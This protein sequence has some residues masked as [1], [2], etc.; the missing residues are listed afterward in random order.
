MWLN[1][2][3]RQR[4]APVNPYFMPLHPNA[5][6]AGG[7]ATSTAQAAESNAE[8]DED[9]HEMRAMAKAWAHPEDVHL[10]PVCLPCNPTSTTR[11]APA[12]CL[13]IRHGKSFGLFVAPH[14]P[15]P[16]TASC[17]PWQEMD[18]AGTRLGRASSWLSNSTTTPY[19]SPGG[20]IPPVVS[21]VTGNAASVGAGSIP[22]FPLIPLLK[23]SAL[24][25][26]LSY[27]VPSLP[28]APGSLKAS[29][30]LGAVGC[31]V[32]DSRCIVEAACK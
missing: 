16:K 19:A 13:L 21:G 2:S 11:L 29:M 15:C 22:P 14:R 20:G 24:Q 18:A 28:S 10:Y 3:L 26:E 8:C 30:A 27:K 31:M 9:D 23:V 12:H 4:P 7:E 17:T 1:L 6:Q 25:T 32:R 5:R